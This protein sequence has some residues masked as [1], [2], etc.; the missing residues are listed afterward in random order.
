MPTFTSR[1]LPLVLF[2]LINA[3]NISARGGKGGGR[4]SSSS[5]FSS[6]N[7]GSMDAAIFA[8]Y[9]IFAVFTA[10]QVFTAF[11]A[12]RKRLP[13][14][15]YPRRIPYILLILL[16]VLTL[17]STYS[18]GAV[19]QSQANNITV[20]SVDW[21]TVLAML[22][23]TRTLA[24]VFLYAGLLLL[25]DYR[26]TIQAL[27]YGHERSKQFVITL[28]CVGGLFLLLMLVCEIARVIISSTDSLTWYLGEP[29]PSAV[30]AYIALYHLFIAS[31]VITTIVICAASTILWT[32]SRPAESQYDWVM[33]DTHVISRL[34][35]SIFFDTVSSPLGSFSDCEDH[36]S[37]H[38]YSRYIRA[39]S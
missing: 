19:I 17:I 28:R 26:S 23:F 24:H 22:G 16:V 30:R 32:N 11:S 35:F 39:Y 33:Y 4:G 18:L 9:I 15:D 1:V 38:C 14:E 36:L 6:L 8:M 12:L 37:H 31:Y 7:L 2:I 20:T 10:F 13:D 25:L 3:P 5:S 34:F 27:Q 21:N 29:Q